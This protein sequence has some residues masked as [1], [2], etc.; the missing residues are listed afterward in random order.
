MLGDLFIQTAVTIARS[1]SDVRFLLPAANP[2]IRGE[3]ERLADAFPGLPLQIIEGDSQT[4]MAAADTLLMAS[5]TATLEAMLLKR[6]MVVAYR[7][8]SLSYAIISRLLHTPYIAL[9]NLLAGEELV[10]EFVQAAAHP[11]ALAEAVLAQLDNE[12]LRSR[13]VQRFAVQHEQLRR[14]AGDAVAAALL[15]LTQ[16]GQG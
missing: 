11:E 3:L 5:G 14:N 15:E 13:L 9:P 4:A 7:M 16:V 8:G 10:P 12:S 6:P 2:S 1:R